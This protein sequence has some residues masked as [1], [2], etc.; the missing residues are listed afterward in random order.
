MG[1]EGSVKA[2]IKQKIGKNSGR[3]G[4]SILPYEDLR[5]WIQTREPSG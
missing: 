4:R 5:A 3:K 2:L 1:M